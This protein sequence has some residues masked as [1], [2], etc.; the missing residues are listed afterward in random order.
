M[1]PC[2]NIEIPTS[3]DRQ[4][5]PNKFHHV[6]REKGTYYCGKTILTIIGKQISWPS[7]MR[8]TTSKDTNEILAKRQM[9]SNEID[10][11]ISKFFYYK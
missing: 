3:F 1:S 10:K 2:K 9:T 8:Q 4:N 5:D 7:L 6:I 11:P